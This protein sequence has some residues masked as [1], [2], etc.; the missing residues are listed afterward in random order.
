MNFYK[1]LK[2]SALKINTYLGISIKNNNQVL[3]MYFIKYLKI[4]IFEYFFLI[5]QFMKN[6]L[7][8]KVFRANLRQLIFLLMCFTLFVLTHC[9]S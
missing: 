2:I 8:F 6:R 4:E 3:L 7:M 1:S 9:K 5:Y